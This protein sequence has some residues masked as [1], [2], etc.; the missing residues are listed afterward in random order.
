MSTTM[1]NPPSNPAPPTPILSVRDLAKT[2]VLHA[3]NGRSVVGLAGV[4]LDIPIAQHVCLAGLSGAG[5]SSLLKCVHRTYV[6]DSGS[7]DYLRADGS[8]VNLLDLSH[9]EMADLR[10]REIGYVSQFLR[11]EPRRGV[12]D[13]VTRSATRMG[14]AL[15][16]AEHRAVEVL[17]RVNI[18][19]DL[20]A[21]FPTLLSGGEKQRVNLAAGIVVPPRLLLLDEPVSALDPS[22]RASVLD[23]ISELTPQG[24]TVLSVFHDLPAIRQLADRVVV[25]AHGKVVD[26]G[27]PTDVLNRGFEA[28]P[29]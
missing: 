25:M 11:A 16:Q 17:R 29:V 6:A 12:L 20:W 10:E 7:V 13:V 27:N 1:S 5:K 2:F 22:N 4:D 21:T 18:N 26:E 9:S 15:D 3:V 8:R 28:L 23:L 14:I 24:A 19:E